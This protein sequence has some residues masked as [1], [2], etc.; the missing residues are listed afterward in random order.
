MNVTVS[1]L[2]NYFS[3]FIPGMMNLLNSQHEFKLK[4]ARYPIFKAQRSVGFWVWLIVQLILPSVLFLLLFSELNSPRNDFLSFL[5]LYIQA[6]LVG[7]GFVGAVNSTTYLGELGVLNIKSL[8]CFFLKIC[9]QLIDNEEDNRNSL[10]WEEFG[11][12]LRDCRIDILKKGLEHLIYRIESQEHK[13]VELQESE[14]TSQEELIAQTKQLRDSIN[15][16]IV[17][18]SRERE[19][20]AKEVIDIFKT[21]LKQGHLKSDDL[22]GALRKFEI[23]ESPIEIVRSRE[24][25]ELDARQKSNRVS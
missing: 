6:M 8:Y 25:R 7:I 19:R 2:A 18:I 24:K 17:R 1:N 20:I 22:Q 3:V 13:I 10:F 5:K 9:F 14:K 15:S 12:M 4:V 23:H 11:Q 16:P 21:S